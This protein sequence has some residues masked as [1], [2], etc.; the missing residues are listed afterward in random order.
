MGQVTL[1]LLH[2]SSPV[3]GTLMLLRALSL[4]VT[5]AILFGSVGAPAIAHSQGQ[6]DVHAPNHVQTTG[7]C[8]D[9]LFILH[10]SRTGK[11]CDIYH[12]ISI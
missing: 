8:T 12:A 4:L 5:L 11:L 6:I 2:R 10:S 3:N 7:I 9:P 1:R